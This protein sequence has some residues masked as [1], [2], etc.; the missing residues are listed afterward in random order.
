[1]QITERK[2]PPEP[3]EHRLLYFSLLSLTNSSSLHLFLYTFLLIS[4]FS[5]HVYIFI[6]F[7]PSL[8]PSLHR[9]LSFSHTPF[10]SVCWQPCA[11]LTTAS[12]W[13]TTTHTHSHAASVPVIVTTPRTKPTTDKYIKMG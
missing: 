13:V 11:M 9:F 6:T 7:P 5:L 1:M 8:P 4:P 3:A 12:C 10:L 2:T